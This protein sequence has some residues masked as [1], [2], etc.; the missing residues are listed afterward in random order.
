MEEDLSIRQVKV[1]D[2]IL[3]NED[4]VLLYG[5]PGVGKTEIIQQLAMKEAEE[6]GR[7]FVDLS[8]A[9][10]S[11]IREIIQNPKE[12][13]VFF[14]LV[15]PHTFPEDIGFPHKTTKAGI[16]F[17]KIIP[18]DTYAIFALKDIKGTLFIDELTNVARDD[19]MAM[20]YSL[21]LEKQLGP[22]KLN[23]DVK[24]FAAGNPPEW[25]KASSELPEPILSRVT[26][27]YVE[28]PTIDEWI[29][30]MN[31]NYGDKWDRRIAAFLKIYPEDLLKKPK[32]GRT[33]GYPTP[34]SWTL[35]A[36]KLWHHLKKMEEL[37]EKGDLKGMKK[38]E[39]YIYATI[40][41]TV[42]PEVGEKY[43]AFLKTQIS[44]KLLE[45]LKENP[46]LFDSLNISQKAMV[47]YSISQY[48]VEKIIEYNEK[49]MRYLVKKHAEFAA[50]LIALIPIKE[51][52]RLIIEAISK[53]PRR[54]SVYEE[55][56][57]VLTS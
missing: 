48:P 9:D 30:Y 41:G 12:F 25:S 18:L 50:L 57:N 1:T 21:I 44:Q 32:R 54:S 3:E 6:L 53:D 33:I 37:E 56:A 51:R 22:I 28:P 2:I 27:L 15:A 8:E 46:E 16:S 42:G 49:F 31:K 38:L 34:R 4:R 55:L 20:F 11:I 29:E 52:K 24:I 26:T 19:Q 43:I 17:S 10:E 35:L 13:Y 40:D 5:P 23:R 7:K 47:V 36:T 45:D 39:R 14:R